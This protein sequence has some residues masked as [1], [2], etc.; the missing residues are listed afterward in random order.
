MTDETGVEHVEQVLPA[1]RPLVGQPTE[2]D[3]VGYRPP[4]IGAAVPS[5]LVPCDDCCTAW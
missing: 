4:V 5:R 3:P 1:V 2:S